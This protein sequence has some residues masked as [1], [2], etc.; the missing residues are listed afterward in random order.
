VNFSLILATV[1]RTYDL[2]HFL[3]TLDGQQ[4]RRFEVLVVDQ[5]ADD[6]LVD[7]LDLYKNRMAIR[8]LR[9]S[10]GLSHARNA[11]LQAATGD[12]LAFPDDDCWYSPDLLEQVA[13]IL[14]AQPRWDG[15]SGR[16]I[17]ARGKSSVTRWDRRYGAITPW[18]VWRRVTSAAMFLRRRVVESV[19]DFDESL[20]AGAAGPWRAGEEIDYLLRA[21]AGGFRLYYVPGLVVHHSIPLRDPGAAFGYGMGM[22]RVLRK[23]RYPMWFVTYHCLRPLIGALLASLSGDRRRAG[24]HL[25]VLRGRVL[26]WRG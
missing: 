4:Y 7:L 12:V 23:H 5:N 9:T 10:R 15:V 24:Y 21:L 13:S 11:G 25:A 3:G 26:G 19:G 18:N 14:E 6:R 1:D 17:D 16:T 22:G 20:G 2:Q 8:H